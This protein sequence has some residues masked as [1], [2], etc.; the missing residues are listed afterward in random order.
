[1]YQLDFVIWVENHLNFF[2]YLN[3][4]QNNIEF[5]IVLQKNKSVTNEN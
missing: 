2:W 4:Y 3:C 5:D 1:M